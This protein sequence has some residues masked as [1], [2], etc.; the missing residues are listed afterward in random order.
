MDGL[1]QKRKTP[2]GA[3]V[4]DPVFRSWEGNPKNGLW[5]VNCEKY[6]RS[7]RWISDYVGSAGQ[8]PRRLRDRAALEQL[9]D[10]VVT[11]LIHRKADGSINDTVTAIFEAVLEE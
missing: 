10:K 2:G 11:K 3:T 4:Y 6:G 8:L 5:I 7:F 1:Y 9:R